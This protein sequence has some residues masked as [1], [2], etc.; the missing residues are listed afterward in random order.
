M[1]Q[2]TSDIEVLGKNGAPLLAESGDPDRIVAQFHVGSVTADVRAQDAQRGAGRG[3]QAEIRGMIK[4]QRLASAVADG[5]CS[6]SEI[7]T[8]SD[9]VL[10]V[11]IELRR[12]GKLP[13]VKNPLA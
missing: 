10:G 5:L 11:K 9:K 4:S 6:M 1:T 8:L 13:H 12:N 3:L 2:K 7:D